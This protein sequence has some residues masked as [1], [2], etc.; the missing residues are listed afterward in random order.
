VRIFVFAISLQR[1]M[2]LPLSWAGR[3]GLYVSL[4][5]QQGQRSIDPPVAARKR[6]DLSF[7]YSRRL[8]DR[9]TEAFHEDRRA[10]GFA[11]VCRGGVSQFNVLRLAVE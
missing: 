2:V 6:P 9:A 11:C 1:V 5:K 8:L 3:S 7:A 4:H 10:G